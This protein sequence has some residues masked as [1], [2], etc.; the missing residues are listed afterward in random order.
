MIPTKK[1]KRIQRELGNCRP[2]SLTPILGTL[3]ERITK[4]RITKHTVL[5]DEPAEEGPTNFS[6]GK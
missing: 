2:V 6:K 3:E 1:E 4:V 5:K